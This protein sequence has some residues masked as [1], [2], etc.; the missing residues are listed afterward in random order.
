MLLTSL[1]LIAGMAQAVPFS[2]DSMT[3]AQSM[4]LKLFSKKHD[5]DQFSWDRGCNASS[6]VIKFQDDADEYCHT[7]PVGIPCVFADCMSA[8]DV[9]SDHI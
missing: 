4:C 9:E 7:C 1:L 6:S 3:P 2:V 5:V 8:L